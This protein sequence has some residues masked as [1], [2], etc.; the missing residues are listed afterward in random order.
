MGM[1]G[2]GGLWIARGTNHEFAADSVG[3]CWRSVRI[4]TTG[5]KGQIPKREFG[6]I[7]LHARYTL[8]GLIFGLMWGFTWVPNPTRSANRWL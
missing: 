4:G 6:G 1:C 3:Q 2:S 8:F 7:A 5:P